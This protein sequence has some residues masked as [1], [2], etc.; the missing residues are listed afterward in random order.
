MAHHVVQ[1][2][3]RRMS[4]FSMV[5]V[6]V[7]LVIGMLASIVV[8]EMFSNSEGRNRTAA[9]SADAQSNGIM[10]LYQMQSNIQRGGY[11]LN[12]ISLFNCNAIWKVGAGAGTDI[13]KP[14]TL[15]PVAINPVDTANVLKIPAGD[16]NSDVLV[17][18]FGTGNSESEGNEI[19]ATAVP[20]YTVRSQGLFA[21][22]DRV[23]AVAAPC[24]ATNLTID[25]LTASDAATST[26]TAVVGTAGNILFNLGPGPNGPNAAPTAAMPS[27][28]PAV[29][30]YA[31]RNGSLTVCDFN[32]ND[33]S[34]DS[35]KGLVTVWV[36]LTDNIVSMRAAY[37]RDNSAA[38]NG[39]TPA[40]IVINQTQPTTACDWA[41][42]RAINL[43]LVTRSVERDRDVVTNTAARVLNASA[44]IA[45]T[46]SSAALNAAAPVVLG[47][48]DATDQEWRHY[49]YKAFQAM[50]PLR[51][52]SWMGSPP[53]GCP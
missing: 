38:W 17:V 47:T 30:V 48:D 29:L 3:S 41:R 33:C 39:A 4:G 52:V 26:V 23:I 28:G 7:A 34:K 50:M 31:V 32:I 45:P 5:E 22:G 35:N 36:P 25:R 42:V 51:N 18:M 1:S 11:G 6:L 16:T 46:W 53:P 19:M 2:P 9:G 44:A 14:V 13:T 20:V 37:W 21:V 40:D 24:G 49:R 15:A 12:S 8:L 27:N 43:L 10:T